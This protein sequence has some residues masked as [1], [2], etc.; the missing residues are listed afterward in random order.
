MAIILTSECLRHCEG[1]DTF[2]NTKVE[3]YE[4][5]RKRVRGT[6]C[7]KI[8][9]ED[10]NFLRIGGLNDKAV[11]A[12]VFSIENGEFDA[13]LET[14]ELIF[15]EGVSKT[16]HWFR[17]RF[18]SRIFFMIR[19]VIWEIVERVG[20]NL[21][22]YRC[23]IRVPKLYPRPQESVALIFEVLLLQAEGRDSAGQ[24]PRAFFGKS[25]E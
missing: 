9:D 6:F 3:F 19:S 20:L 5:W 1:G 15:L 18:F 8:V 10:L 12:R 22:V 7:L 23:R 13:S 17:S 11:E 14:I 16:F 2:G 21:E 24:S 25:Q 4:I